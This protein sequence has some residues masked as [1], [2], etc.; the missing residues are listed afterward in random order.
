LQR[1]KCDLLHRKNNTNTANRLTFE[2]TT[3]PSNSIT[4][5]DKEDVTMNVLHQKRYS[6]D[7]DIG[8]STRIT[9]NMRHL[10]MSTTDFRGEE[11][12]GEGGGGGVV[13][14]GE[15]KADSKTE[16]KLI[17]PDPPKET[18]EDRFVNA[19][20]RLSRLNTDLAN[21]RNLLAWAR[22]A[23]ASARTFLAF[24]GV[25]AVTN[26]GKA[27]RQICYLGFAVMSIYIIL[28]GTERYNK[29]KRIVYLKNPPPNFDRLTN[30]PLPICLALLFALGLMSISFDQWED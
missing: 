26:F 14:K 23:L 4:T 18:K 12:T 10:V 27:S 1:L 5:E 17:T 30:A 7:T 2:T 15:E 28:Q 16:E 29:I 6:K 25:S 20:T 9:E 13:Q 11:K 3:A 24:V 19:M 21:E 8:L 22:T